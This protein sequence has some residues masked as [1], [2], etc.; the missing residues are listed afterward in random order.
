MPRSH[1]RTTDRGRYTQ[2]D[3][4]N[5]LGEI[6][7]GASQ[8]DAAINNNMSAA[9]FFSRVHFRPH[10]LNG[11]ISES[12]GLAAKSGWINA[13]LFL[14]VFRHF[15]KYVRASKDNQ[16]LLLMD[17]HCSH[18]SL[19]VIRLADEHGVTICY[20]YSSLQ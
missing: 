11:G 4:N 3:I 14:D 5:A 7:G 13:D 1:P 6:D 10:K 8:R 12:L 17:N 20:P 16:T 9:T 18:V 15:I 19:D 2:E